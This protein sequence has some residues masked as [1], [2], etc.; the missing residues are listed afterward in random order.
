MAEPPCFV[1]KIYNAA[2][3]CTSSSANTVPFTY[4]RAGGYGIR[5]AMINKEK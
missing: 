3:A 5:N 2:R 1:T 4:T